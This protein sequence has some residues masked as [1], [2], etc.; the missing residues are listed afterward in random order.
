MQSV[1]PAVIQISNSDPKYLFDTFV[2]IM[3]I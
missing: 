2:H 1:A 3:N